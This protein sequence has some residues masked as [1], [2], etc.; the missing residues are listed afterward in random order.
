MAL[1]SLETRAVAPVNGRKPRDGNGASTQELADSRFD[2]RLA[3]LLDH[4]A[5]IFC[6]KG[7]EGASMRDLS[8]AT[9]MSLA[10][11]YHYF[12]S[13]EELLYLIQKHTFETIIANLLPKLQASKDPDERIRIFIENH[14]EY[15][16][17]NKEAMKVLV[18]EDETL[19]NE[20]GAE[21]RAI[22]RDYYRICLEL[23]EDFER[24]RGLQFSGRLAVMS[25]FGMINWI[26]TWH[27]PRVD[28]NAAE[29]AAQM[30]DLFLNGVL[31]NGK[32]KTKTG[33]AKS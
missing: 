29:L 1:D 6:D 12:A 2:R 17:A 23:L 27:N 24:A 8:R 28:A 25:L 21:V 22:K 3:K 33:R 26:Y 18:H 7:Y 30:G 5:R 19:K 11:L 31:N 15:S 13:K 4:A 32:I 9:G 20:H 10:G 16:L 14:L